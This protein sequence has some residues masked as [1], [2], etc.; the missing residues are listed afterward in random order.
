MRFSPILSLY[1]SR[2]FLVAFCGALGIIMGL[3]YLFDVVE[4]L[5]RAA[6]HGDAGFT[7]ILELALLKLPQMVQTILPFAVMI[8]AMACFW[9]MTRSRELVV[10]RSAGIS[11]WQ[12]LAPVGG[13]VFMIGILNV[14]AFN[15]LSARM[16]QRYE[17]LQDDMALRG[18]NSGKNSLQVGE[19]GLW[20]RETHGD[21]QVVIHA[22]SVWQE[23]LSLRLRGVSV[24]VSDN[25]EHFEYRLE[26]AVGLL[27]PTFFHLEQVQLYRAERP[28]EEFPA[29]DFDTQLTMERV[30]DNFASPETISF[31]EL[32][33]FIQFFEKAG[34]S[35]SRQK[36]YF[37]SMLASPLLL[38]AMV[39]VAAVFSLRPDMRSGG[40]MARLS[41]GVVSGF[42]FYFFSKV[43]YAL[44]LS[45]TLPVV[46]AAWI[47]AVVTGLVGMGA[48]FHLEDG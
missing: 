45:S 27:Q 41:G 3:I 47:P 23:N 10:S 20:L 2:H 43:I 14:T 5:R 35:A 33:N 22:D 39:L 17:Q 46:M 48:L 37:Q 6:T 30:Q 8:G 13:V 28:V 9:T 11:V 34:F 38:C 18:G 19:A 32:P 36:L 26:A 7:T 4:L 25:K 40:I 21:E 31:W 1:I 24:F 42:I 44:G 12:F 29:Y 16:Y 15:P